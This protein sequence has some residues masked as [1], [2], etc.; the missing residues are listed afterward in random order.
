[1]KKLLGF[2]NTKP[3][4]LFHYIPLTGVV[5][6]AHYL[7]VNKYFNLETAVQANTVLGWAT[8]ALWYYAFLL[9]GDNLIHTIIGED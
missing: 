8:L 9:I 4:I 3:K 7:S 1:M 6:L 5:F 2:I